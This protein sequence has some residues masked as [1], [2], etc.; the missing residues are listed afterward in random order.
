M[1]SDP[2]SSRS[3]SLR[4]RGVTKQ[5]KDTCIGD[6]MVASRTPEFGLPVPDARAGDSD[7]RA[8]RRLRNPDPLTKLA[9]DG[10]RRQCHP[11]R[12][13]LFQ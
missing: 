11:R 8:D 2:E 1:T 4:A 12:E 5:L 9:T 10:G 6:D 7:L 13:V 3:S